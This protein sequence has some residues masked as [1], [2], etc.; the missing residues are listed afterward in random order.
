M[1]QYLY[2]Q[3]LKFKANLWLWGLRDFR[4]HRTKGVQRRKENGKIKIWIS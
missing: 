4:R 2:P 1:T 3:N